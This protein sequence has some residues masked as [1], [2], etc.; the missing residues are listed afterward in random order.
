MENQLNQVLNFVDQIGNAEDSLREKYLDIIQRKIDLIQEKVSNQDQVEDHP[1]YKWMIK[2]YGSVIF[3]GKSLK[4]EGVLKLI[5]CIESS[6]NIPWESSNFDNNEGPLSKKYSMFPV[7]D[8]DDWYY[9][10]LQES[11]FWSA[12][13]LDFKTDKQQYEKLPQ[14][15]KEL[16]K[17]QLKFF[18]SADGIITDQ[19]VRYIKEADN[20]NQMMFLIFQIAIEAVHSEAYSM[21]SVSIITDAKEQEE[22]FSSVDKLEC[23]KAKADFTIKYN[24][25][26]HTRGFRYFVGAISEGIFF[27]SLFTVIFYLRSKNFLPTFIHMNKLISSDETIHRNYNCSKVKKLKGISY[28]EAIQVLEEAL[29][30]E[31]GF[32]RYILREPVDSLEADNAAGLTIDNLEKFI[33]GLADQILVLSGFPSY[34]NISVDLPWMADLSLSRKNNFYETKGGNYKKFSVTD[35]V[36]WQE[37][38]GLKEKVAYNVINDPDQEDF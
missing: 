13:E 14:R 18:N 24:K 23:V 30:I 7:D 6:G 33:K 19:V 3:N 29:A 20:Y 22:I 5:Q 11:N 12:K 35:A 9:Y 25:S 26:D 10:C 37:R 15:Y 1:F 2:R 27:V 16:Y 38:A 36:D 28:Q 8:E 17:D 31:M 32:L 21:S 34:Y 4:K